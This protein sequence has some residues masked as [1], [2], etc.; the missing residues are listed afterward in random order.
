MDIPQELKWSS[1]F[2]LLFGLAGL[3]ALLGA[4]GGIPPLAHQRRSLDL[5]ATIVMDFWIVVFV[6]RESGKIHRPDLVQFRRP[7]SWIRASS[8]AALAGL[9]ALLSVGLVGLKLSA[10]SLLTPEA[11]GNSVSALPAP[12]P[13]VTVAL[14]FTLAVLIAPVA[15]ELLFRVY[16][17]QLFARRFSHLASALLVAGLFGLLHRDALGA[18]AFSLTMTVLLLRTQSLWYP[19]L[20]HSIHNLVAFGGSRLL[21]PFLAAETVSDSDAL[22]VLLGASGVMLLVALPL[23]V[24]FVRRHLPRKAKKLFFF[25]R[26]TEVG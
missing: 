11:L 25:E 7:A 18:L 24:S 2:R 15:E 26:W 10:L 6:L 9:L 19:I 3:L 12:T 5:A 22:A 21:L 8:L 4:I 13:W 23:F 17:F 1:I 14:E 16:L 20:F